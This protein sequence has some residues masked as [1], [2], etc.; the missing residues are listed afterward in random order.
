MALSTREATPTASRKGKMS[1]FGVEH[2]THELWHDLKPF[3]VIGI[4]VV[5]GAI[6]VLFKKKLK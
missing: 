3:L 1:E 4:T 2:V 6:W 5:V